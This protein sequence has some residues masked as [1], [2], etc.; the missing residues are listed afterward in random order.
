[1]NEI[2]CNEIILLSYSTL[3]WLICSLENKKRKQN[4][5]FKYFRFYL[6]G[7]MNVYSKCKEHVWQEV[8]CLLNDLICELE[9][10]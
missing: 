3:N 10:Y 8:C 9:H 1:M 2:G 5:C 4:I 6:I 7:R